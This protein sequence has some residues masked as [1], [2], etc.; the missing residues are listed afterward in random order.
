M[1]GWAGYRLMKKLKELR[2]H[3]RVWNKKVFGNIDSL[4]KSAEE[5]L[6]DWD[7]KAESR[8]LADEDI[9]RRREARSLGWKLSGDKERLW[10]Q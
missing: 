8:S 7:L 4:L 5:E 10:H 3:L 2:S 9:R 1:S 6:H